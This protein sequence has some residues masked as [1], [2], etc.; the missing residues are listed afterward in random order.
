MSAFQVCGFALAAVILCTITREHSPSFAL[1]VSFSCGA[2][3]FMLFASEYLNIA[4]WFSSVM[5]S[6]GVKGEHIALTLKVIGSAYIVE[7]AAESCEEA[8]LPLLASKVTLAG[9]ALLISLS[10]PVIASMISLITEKMA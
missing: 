10:L 8:G 4:G 2:I 6:A 5:K 1:L 7:F 3:L 9:K